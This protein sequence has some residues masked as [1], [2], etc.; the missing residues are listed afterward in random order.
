MLSGEQLSRNVRQERNALRS[1][2]V[3]EGDEDVRG[4]DCELRGGEQ[5]HR[6]RRDGHWQIERRLFEGLALRKHVRGDDEERQIHAYLITSKSGNCTSRV[7]GN[8]QT[9]ESRFHDEAGKLSGIDCNSH[10]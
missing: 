6:H 8:G 1:V 2:V 4:V 9:I 3:E 10:W 7:A 5:D